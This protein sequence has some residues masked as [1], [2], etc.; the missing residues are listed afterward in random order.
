MDGVVVELKH[1]E[2]MRCA[3]HTVH[4]VHWSACERDMGCRGREH[5]D[6][7]RHERE[8]DCICRVGELVGRIGRVA[9]GRAQQQ[10]HVSGAGTPQT[11]LV[12]PN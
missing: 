1:L 10:Q 9:A 12:R 4:G 11:F 5:D 8:A 2:R 6:A 3:Q 7:P